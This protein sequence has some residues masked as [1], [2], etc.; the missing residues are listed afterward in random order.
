[1][2]LYAL[3]IDDNKI[4]TRPMDL[5][6]TKQFKK[7]LEEEKIDLEKMLG[8][9]AKKDRRIE[10]DWETKFAQFGSHT[11]EQ[12][13]N[14]DE[15]EEYSNLLPVE[16]SLELRLQEVNSALKKIKEKKYGKCEKCK[17]EIPVERLRVNPAAKACLDH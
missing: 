9:F 10:G 7:K 17:K 3:I 12:D 14:A 2:T 11:S 5:K 6:T 15:V 16:Y 13:E 4:K 1:M 8:Q